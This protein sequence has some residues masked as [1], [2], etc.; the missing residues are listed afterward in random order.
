MSREKFIYSRIKYLVAFIIFFITEVLI[1][2]YVHDDFIRP[3]VGDILVVILL[4]CF[5]KIFVPYKVKLMS[6]YIFIFSAFVEILQYFKLVEVL[7][8]QDNR[9]A[10]IVIGSVFDWKDIL[11]YGV[12]CILLYGYE[13]LIDK[14]L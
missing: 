3:Y 12:G 4:Y 2:V 11:C 1:A 8:L 7:G 5:I 9:F 6:L 10:R 14:S 13:K